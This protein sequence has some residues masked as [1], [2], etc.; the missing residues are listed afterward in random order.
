MNLTN[1]TDVFHV[2]LN[3]LDV[4]HELVYPVYDSEDFVADDDLVIPRPYLKFRHAIFDRDEEVFKN[5]T[6]RDQNPLRL[7][8]FYE[9]ILTFCEREYKTETTDGITSSN[10]TSTDYGN[11]FE[12]RPENS[13]SGRFSRFPEWCWRP[14]RA[15]GDLTLTSDD[16]KLT[17]Q[18]KSQ[19]AFCTFGHER[20]VDP[21]REI[22]ESNYSTP[23]Y[24]NQTDASDNI[25]ELIRYYTYYDTSE[26]V[27]WSPTNL[28]LTFE[29]IAAALTSYGLSTSNLTVPG[30]AML[31]QSYVRVRWQWIALPAFLELASL[32][33]FLS[34]VV[35]SRRIGVP[36]W[37]SSL[38]AVCYHDIKEL[39]G[40][41]R[42]SLLSDIDKDSSTTSVQFFRDQDEPGF[43]LR[44]VSLKRHE[45]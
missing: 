4:F 28:S 25:T 20:Y 21:I 31:P 27:A 3:R 22:V 33:L 24:F 11:F 2:V 32:V 17:Y 13:I 1:L 42:L 37:K 5:L 12:F 43:L 19:R 23:W 14:N 29:N 6:L 41:E 39:R 8:Q 30:K 38:L 34:T 35:Y 16:A 10:V 40:T 44:R 18:D 36:I 9:C 15:L 7:D 26:G 45:D